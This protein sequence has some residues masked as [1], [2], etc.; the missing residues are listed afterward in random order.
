M[1]QFFKHAAVAIGGL[2]LLAGCSSD[3]SSS[4]RSSRTYDE[5]T[6]SGRYDSTYGGGY[7]TSSSSSS[8]SSGRYDT[9]PG[10]N[11]YNER[12]AKRA[13]DRY[14]GEERTYEE[15]KAARRSQQ[16]GY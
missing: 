9:T 7:G 16:Y 15:R 5:R 3:G 11:D 14:N 4:S 12:K 6:A 10:Y 1:T 2:A 13:A 8:T